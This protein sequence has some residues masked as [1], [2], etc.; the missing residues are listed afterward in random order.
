MSLSIIIPVYNEIHQLEYT[1][2]KLIK[3]KKK[4]RML[5]LFLLMIL[6]QMSLSKLSNSIVTKD[7][8]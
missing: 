6:V 4:L 2:K 8:I 1:I 7:L 3:L 5:S